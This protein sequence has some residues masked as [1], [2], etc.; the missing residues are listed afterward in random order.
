MDNSIF[1]REEYVY[2]PAFNFSVLQEDLKPFV[3]REIRKEI[4]ILD[5]Y[6]KRNKEIMRT[7]C[8]SRD[9]IEQNTFILKELDQA[10]RI[11]TKK[12]LETK[13]KWLSRPRKSGEGDREK[14]KR[15]AKLVPLTNIL[16]FNQAGFASCPLHTDKTPS[17]KYY[18]KD[19]H[20]HCYSCDTGGDSIDL[21]MA[22]DNVDFKKAIEYLI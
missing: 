2:L 16:K 7:I 10:E 20:W 1:E 22:R 12:K 6:L 4:K 9:K 21:V 15:L 13:L 18:E 14:Q 11:E 8:G 17:L 5:V 19:N 3:L